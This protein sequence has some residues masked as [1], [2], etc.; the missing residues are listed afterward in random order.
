MHSLEQACTSPSKDWLPACVMSGSAAQVDNCLHQGSSWTLM[1]A[2][3]CAGM[4]SGRL[5]AHMLFSDRDF[6][7]NDYE[8]LLALDEGIENRKGGQRCA[9]CLCHMCRLWA[10]SLRQ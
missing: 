1:A 6:D 2:G 10:A 3:V 7:E 9:A 8:A 5:P 4:N